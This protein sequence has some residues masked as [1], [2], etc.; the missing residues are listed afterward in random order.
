M[1]NMKLY[2][3]AL[4]NVKS[5]LKNYI[6]LILSLAFTIMIFYNF[7]NM[8]DSEMFT[9]FGQLNADYSRMLIQTLSVVLGVF[10]IFFIG[11]ATNVFLNRRKK[12]I[13]IFIFM[14]LT[15]KRIGRLYMIE[16]L[17]V[18]VLTLL[19]GVVSGIL[20]SQL[21]QMILLAMS[22]MGTDI[23]FSFSIRSV[24]VTSAFYF[25]IY[26]LFVLKGYFNIIRSSVMEL[27]SASRQNES[28]RQRRSVL[29]LKTILGVGILSSGC[30]L[31]VKD[32]KEEILENAVKAVVLVIIGV[33][34]LFGGLIP[35]V[36]QGLAKNKTFLY[37]RERD[38]WVNQM[39]FRMKKNYR[40]YAMVCV[41]MICS[42]TALSASF[43][44]KERYQ[45]MEHFRNT[46]TYQLLSNQPDL[47][48]KAKQ[49]IGQENEIAYSTK[50][51]IL[52]LEQSEKEKQAAQPA[53]SLLA[54]SELQQLAQDAGLNLDITEPEDGKTYE[55]THIYLMSL[56]TKRKD[57]SV[58]MKDRTF[59]Q[60]DEIQEPYLG[61]LQESMS[62]YLVNDREYEKLKPFGQQLYAYNYRIRDIYNYKASQDALA[63]LV[64]NTQ[65][66]YTARIVTGPDSGRDREWIKIL[67]SLCIYLVM[68][69]VMAS[70]SILFMKLYNDAFE[71]A[72]RYAILQ[73]MGVVQRTLKRAVSRELLVSYILPLLIMA[74][75]SYFS[76]YAMEKVMHTGLKE[77][78]LVSVAVIVLFFYLCYRISVA[79]Y[80]KNAGIR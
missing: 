37:R 9:K 74:A 35:A 77:I 49:L 38:L 17:M 72:G 14:G 50:I 71:E 36:L 55:V 44:F 26:F 45:S 67:Y 80:I 76:V 54:W 19:A 2:E 52:M 12:E 27:V 21:F 53:V 73:K 60:I 20:T 51:S 5:N 40:T 13:G 1:K 58:Q 28:V 11:Y 70:G 22:Q 4:Q 15:N 59:L 24:F 25:L 46:Y 18:F 63:T 6:S 78:W 7:Q 39:I 23:G 29:Y 64:S 69:F 33:Y 34:F 10:M 8:A 48:E 31:A 3:L 75:A 41:L 79:V 65:E 42:V 56:I 57:V 47:D 16:M 66:N 30:L 43:A 32:G 61:Y 68:V 62:F